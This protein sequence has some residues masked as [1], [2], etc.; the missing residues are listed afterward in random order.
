VCVCVCVFFFFFHVLFLFLPTLFS[1]V[2]LGRLT[3]PLGNFNW[4]QS[5]FSISG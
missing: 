3:V 4:M 2:T 5:D 1:E